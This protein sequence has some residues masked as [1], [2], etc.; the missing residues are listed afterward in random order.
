MSKITKLGGTRSLKLESKEPKQSWE[1]RM[2]K[3]FSM[4]SPKQKN[5]KHAYILL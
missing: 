1:N 5:P 3:I 4:H 2:Y